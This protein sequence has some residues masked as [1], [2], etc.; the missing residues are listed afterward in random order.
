MVDLLRTGSVWLEAKRHAQMASSV[1][2]YRGADSVVL[3]A[4]VGRTPFDQQDAEGVLIQTEARDYLIR[5]GDLIIDGNLVVPEPGDQIRE[6]IAEI[7][8]RYD[9]MAF[10]GEPCY[11]YSD[12]YQQTYRIHTKAATVATP[13]V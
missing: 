2:Y 3:L 9:V 7:V 12:Q 11:R 8:F 6:T 10:G 13:H 4:T 5:V 1:T